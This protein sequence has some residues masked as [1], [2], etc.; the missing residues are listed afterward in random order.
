MRFSCAVNILSDRSSAASNT[1]SISVSIAAA[2][3]TAVGADCISLLYV[4]KRHLQW[5]PQRRVFISISLFVAI[6]IA[7][8][9]HV[10][11]DGLT[12]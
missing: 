5:K 12:L 7:A 2:A 3:S 4:S 6:A 1:A 10:G 9:V 11:I 8:A